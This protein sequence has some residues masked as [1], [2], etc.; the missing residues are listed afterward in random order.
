[1]AEIE[2]SVKSSTPEVETLKSFARLPFLPFMRVPPGSPGSA[3][4]S[5]VQGV[6]RAATLHDGAARAVQR[7]LHEPQGLQEPQGGTPRRDAMP[8]RSRAQSAAAHVEFSAASRGFASEG[9]ESAM[10]NIMKAGASQSANVAVIKT[11]KAMDREL[12]DLVG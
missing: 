7:S 8:V 6:Q 1:M 10:L 3:M 9:L 5:G 11:A 12:I 2:G 4:E